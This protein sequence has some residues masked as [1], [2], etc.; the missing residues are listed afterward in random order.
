MSTVRMLFHTKLVRT[1]TTLS[2]GLLAWPHPSDFNHVCL[3]LATP[4]QC[5]VILSMH[6]ATFIFVFYLLCSVL[7]CHLVLGAA[8][9]R[10]SAVL[11]CTLLLEAP[12]ASSCSSSQ[13]GIYGGYYFGEIEKI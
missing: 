12:A 3:L 10:Y 8:Q 6:S 13:R 5:T 11:Y 7:T 2:A 4:Q 9:L 1:P